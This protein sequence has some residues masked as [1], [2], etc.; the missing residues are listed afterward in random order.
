MI[1]DKLS[2]RASAGLKHV[3]WLLTVVLLTWASPVVLADYHAQGC[4]TLLLS[5]NPGRAGLNHYL[6][7]FHEAP[8]AEDSYSARGALPDQQA[9]WI[10]LR[11]QDSA[12]PQSDDQYWFRLTLTN[13]TG[14]TGYWFLKLAYAPLDYV[15]F[16]LRPRGSPASETQIIAT[17]DQRS[18]MSR[19]INYRHYLVPMEIEA[20]STLDI[21]VAVR[22]AGAMNVPLSVMEPIAMFELANHLTFANG[23]FYGAIFIFMVFNLL[24]FFTTGTPYYFYN[25]FY[26]LAAGLFLFAMGGFGF[27]YLWPGSNWLA[28]AS[29]PLLEIGATLSFILFGRSFLDVG[30]DHRRIDLVLK[31]LAAFSVLAFALVLLVPYS[32]IILI[33]TAYALV[34]ITVLLAIGILRWQQGYTP[35]KWYV[36]AW[37]M[38]VSFTFVYALAAFGYLG[39]FFVR[40]VMMQLAICSQIVLLNYAIIQRWRLLNDRLLEV[41]TRA[42][43]ELESRVEERT[44]QLRETMRQLEQANQ[45][46]ASIS[47]HDSLTGLLNRRFLDQALPASCAEAR[48]NGKPLALVLVDADRFK[49]LNDSY[50]HAFGDQCLK[51]IADA[52]SHH[53]RRPRDIVARFGGEEFVLL[54]PDTELQGA[55][56]VC[57]HAFE[58]IRRAHPVTTEGVAVALSVSAGI[59]MHDPED[60]PE[61]LFERADMA[62]YEAK[63]GGRDRY[64]VA[65]QKTADE[66][67]TP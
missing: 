45:Q 31:G 47:N 2:S 9:P 56:A 55:I 40:E 54:L 46:L 38:F 14:R 65:E 24:I 23:L 10:H 51:I 53:A 25:A 15:T 7:Y 61:S 4:P 32:Q 59:A 8:A 30:S 22:N 27:Q 43:H 42:R 52:L 29:I 64:V 62:L 12:F 41:E 1:P 49:P 39:N 37:A 17:G 57:E 6:C 63:K 13:D 36:L 44:A 5:D 33:A 34:S 20:G 35:A 19:G 16:Y 18:F 28:N 58:D 3:L 48:R 21:V 26:M 67:Q 11:G 66:P 60:S 50:G